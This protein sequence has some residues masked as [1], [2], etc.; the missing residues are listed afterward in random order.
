MVP[1][2][3]GFVVLLQLMVSQLSLN[4]IHRNLSPR[5]SHEM[6]R[7]RKMN[8]SE[9]GTSPGYGFDRPEEWRLQSSGWHSAPHRCACII[10][11][12]FWV[13]VNEYKC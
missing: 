5:L 3:S 1:K 4:R 10:S 6:P 2:S 11:W 7:W 12:V 13:N 9:V 8:K